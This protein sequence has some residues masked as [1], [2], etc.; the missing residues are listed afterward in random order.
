L[1]NCVKPVGGPSTA[2]Q[3]P[4]TNKVLPLHNSPHRRP[5]GALDVEIDGAVE[6]L[7]GIVED[8]LADVQPGRR[9]GN[10]Q[11]REFPAKFNRCQN[12]FIY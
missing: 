11:A 5:H 7:V 6:I 10:I 3:P 2:V 8:G 9:E 4:S 12:R 1:T